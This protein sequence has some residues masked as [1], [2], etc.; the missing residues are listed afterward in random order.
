[1]FKF[2]IPSIPYTTFLQFACAIVGLSITSATLA[3]NVGGDPVYG[4]TNLEAGFVPDPVVIEISPGGPDQVDDLG[5]NCVGFIASAQPDHDLYYESG[6]SVLGIFV[7]AD[8]DTTLVISDPAGT[9]H[10]NDDSSS[11]S[12]ANPGILFESPLSGLYNIWVGT[13][14][15]IGT[16]ATAKL[17][18]TEWGEAQWASLELEASDRNDNIASTGD[19]DFGDDSSMWA[20]DGE[21]DDSRFE[22]D[23][24]ASSLIDSDI[25]HD[26]S[27]C[28]T[29]YDAGAIRLI[30]TTTTNTGDVR[31]GALETSDNTR[32][33]NIYVDTFS[34]SANAGDNAIIDL[35]SGEFDTYLLVNSPSGEQFINDDYES[36]FDRSLLSLN[37]E[38]SGTY[39]V[40]VS[41]FAQD[42]T[43]GYTLT[44][45]TENSGLASLNLNYS[46]QLGSND[47]TLGS[48]EYFD[49][50]SFDGRPGQRVA[51]DLNSNSFDTYVFLRSPSGEQE[52]NDDA[53]GTSRSLIET[54]LTESGSYDV[55]VTSFAAGETGAYELSIGETATA[56]SNVVVNND[57]SSVSI[58]DSITGRLEGSDDLSATNRLEDSYVFT[59]AAGESIQIDMTSSDFDTYLTLVTPNG[60]QIENDDHDGSTAQSRVALTLPEG[61]RFR[62]LVSSYA[63]DMRGNY[64]LSLQRGSA[65]NTST[66][67]IS[68]SN[69]DIYG[70][71]VGM[72]DYPGED[73]DLPLTD[74]DAERAR[75]A[76]INGAG[77][78]PANGTTLLNSDATNANFRSALSRIDASAGPED[79]LVIFYSG[80]GSRVPRPSGPDMFDP[81]GMDETMVLYDGNLID[82]DLAALLADMDVGKVLL[83]MD[84]CFSGGFSKDIVS[85]PGR[86]GLFSSEEDVLSQ[87]A[88]KFQAG[89]YLSVFFEEALTQG[90][91]DIDDN[92][93]LTAIELSQYL[94]NRFRAD[95]K[96]FGSDEY[97]RASGPQANYQQL[98]VDRGGIGPYNVLFTRQ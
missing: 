86:M 82:D 87:V 41:S 61:G 56:T 1:M 33:G 64:N 95:V 16:G 84:S 17:A 62:I 3:Q 69:S 39:Q 5:A 92:G 73:N 11:L 34:F 9:W 4:S 90:Y 23:G 7:N 77:M 93:E 37:L 10:C 98:V 48:G 63:E 68:S 14:E 35:R 80:H 94:H 52:A 47:N 36:S 43:G 85:Q 79:T 6:S 58:G 21:C 15:N 71:F 30:G 26:A 32:D 70:L 28:R 53:G 12:N 22:G 59:A 55:I 60:E 57:T 65:E 67:S 24:V 2:S 27:D 88:F 40:W 89:G 19:V 8:I 13:Y 20:S 29:L 78:N 51:I 74:Q 18:V 38:E 66:A 81:D 42:E 91:A 45:D 46:D 50:Y 72:A 49:V 97:V 83:V 31:R 44:M 54:E 76:L 96:S 75:D 25:Y